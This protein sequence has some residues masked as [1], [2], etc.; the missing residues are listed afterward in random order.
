[1]TFRN[2]NVPHAL[3]I[4]CHARTYC[5]RHPKNL[6]L[7]RNTLVFKPIFFTCI[8]LIVILNFILSLILCS[9][10]HLQRGQEWFAYSDIWNN[11]LLL[12]KYLKHLPEISHS[13]FPGAEMREADWLLILYC[14]MWRAAPDNEEQLVFPSFSCPPDT[15]QL[16][17]F[18]WYFI[19]YPPTHTRTHIF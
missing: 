8:S 7:N 17:C 9:V 3:L 14:Q 16:Y 12:H 2:A 6:H 11:S 18:M 5:R 10:L 4:F 1:M 13:G 19:Y 15:C